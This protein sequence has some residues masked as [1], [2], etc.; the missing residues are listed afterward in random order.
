MNLGS[1]EF[2]WY[3]KLIHDLYS[4]SCGNT[5]FEL[6]VPKLIQTYHCA[7]IY[8]NKLNLT[9]LTY[10]DSP[11]AIA[12]RHCA[13]EHIPRPVVVRV[14]SFTGHFLHVLSGIFQT[15]GGGPQR[16]FVSAYDQFPL[17]VIARFLHVILNVDRIADAVS[18][19][20]VRDLG[21]GHVDVVVLNVK[22]PTVGEHRQINAL[23]INRT[24]VTR[25]VIT[26][27]VK[28]S[29]IH[30][31]TGSSRSIKRSWSTS[32]TYRCSFYYH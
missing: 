27:V 24:R 21:Y 25:M 30:G 12:I 17:I 23:L 15:E 31:H 13:G 28:N 14:Q 8:E 18:I 4:T 26:S 19:T 9:Y 7:R 32:R 11:T 16:T 20:I 22:V 10:L 2:I 29:L 3:Q 1:N 5:A 6:H